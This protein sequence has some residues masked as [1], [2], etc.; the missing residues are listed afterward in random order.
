M[1][2]SLV[3]IVFAVLFLILTLPVLG[4]VSLIHRKDAEKAGRISRAIISWA[5]RVLCVLAGIRITAIGQE[6]IPDDRGAVF[7][8]N[9]RSIYDVIMTYPY[10]KTMGGYIAKDSMEKIPIFSIWMRYI[11]CF[12]LNRTDLKQGMQVILDAIA[13]VRSGKFV[14]IFPE[15]TRNKAETDTP[16]L[17]F[18]EGSFRVAT[19]S[20]APIIPVSICNSVN[21]FER[22]FPWLKATHVIIEFGK[23]IDPT[24]LSREEKKHI[25]EYTREIMTQT[26]EKNS[27]LL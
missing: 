24:S 12:F 4:I 23:P 18:H 25:G 21:V 27:R 26:I 14:F 15:G 1:L 13:Q 17:E 10:M 3:S 22:H 6:N 9:H 5:F 7:I 20:G 11:Y 16:L 2:R 19:K 8:G